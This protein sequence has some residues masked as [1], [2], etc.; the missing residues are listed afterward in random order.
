VDNKK[1]VC[2]FKVGFSSSIPERKVRLTFELDDCNII[3]KVSAVETTQEGEIPLAVSEVKDY[4]H[5]S[6]ATIEE[7]A[8]IE[9]KQMLKDISILQYY[10]NK[11]KFES[12]IYGLKEKLAT[13]AR[14]AD[15]KA[16]LNPKT[17][18]ELLEYFTQ[19]EN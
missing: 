9:R 2:S 3:R 1:A 15:I 13:S 6:E 4:Q 19:L 12:N 18:N 16:F 7:F 5:L 17:Y 10:E 14:N 8:Q 11:N